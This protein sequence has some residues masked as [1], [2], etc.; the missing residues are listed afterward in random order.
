MKQFKSLN[1]TFQRLQ[2][3]VE[4]LT[5]ESIKMNSEYNTIKTKLKVIQEE[6]K[7]IK[8]QIKEDIFA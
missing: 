7:K 1:I 2:S 5:T 4:M 6:Y 8:Q 3:E